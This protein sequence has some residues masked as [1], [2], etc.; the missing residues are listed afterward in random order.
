MAKPAPPRL[1]ERKAAST[2]STPP[3]TQGVTL[4]PRA[5]S[6]AANGSL[7]AP[8]INASQPKAA[9]RATRCGK[10]VSRTASSRRAVSPSPP[11]S[12]TRK[13][14]AVSRSGDTLS[15]QTGIATLNI[16]PPP[17]G[18]ANTVP[19]LINAAALAT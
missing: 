10:A 13:L 16:L 14:D 2:S 12:T 1:P 15:R 18:V 3:A 5:T 11:K 7:T 4:T 6:I 9:I 17:F 19:K 8:Q